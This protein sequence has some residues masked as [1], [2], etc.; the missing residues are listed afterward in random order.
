MVMEALRYWSSC[1][2]RARFHYWTKLT[3]IANEHKE[4]RAL[5]ARDESLWLDTLGSLVNNDVSETKP[6]KPLAARCGTST[7]DDRDCTNN[8][9]LKFPLKLLIAG[10][11]APMKNAVVSSAK[12]MKLTI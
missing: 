12:S 5:H 3:L 7:A 6:A 10:A 8:L 11:M 9:K 1:G 4:L 2:R